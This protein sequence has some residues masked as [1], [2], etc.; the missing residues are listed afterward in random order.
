MAS[1]KDCDWRARYGTLRAWTKECDPVASK[2]CYD[3][4]EDQTR[5]RVDL[6]GKR[7]TPGDRIPSRAERPPLSDTPPTDEELRLAAKKA[8]NGRSGGASKMRAEDLKEWLC[9]AEEEEKMRKKGEE[10]LRVWGINGGCW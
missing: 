4:L 10:G 9:G 6:Y 5:E 8:N 7:D 2:P 3:T 1:L